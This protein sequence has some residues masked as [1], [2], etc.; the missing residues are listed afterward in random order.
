P[1]VC[2]RTALQG[3]SEGQENPPPSPTTP[4]RRCRA[5]ELLRET[6]A[7]QQVSAAR[8]CP[9][10][11]DPAE[12]TAPASSGSRRLST[13]I[14]VRTGQRCRPVRAIAAPSPGRTDNLESQ[15]HSRAIPGGEYPMQAQPGD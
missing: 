6:A 12:S 5:A 7:R 3:N 15:S 13:T 8:G 9:L 2:A 11:Q 10:M 14:A 4:F 1:I